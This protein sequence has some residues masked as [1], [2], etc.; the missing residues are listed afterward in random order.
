MYN[1]LVR[2][3]LNVNECKRMLLNLNAGFFQPFIPLQERKYVVTF[4]MFHITY[5]K[6]NAMYNKQKVGTYTNTKLEN[7]QILQEVNYNYFIII[8]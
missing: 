3:I 5:L 1:A 4:G 7:L 6:P 2:K 8:F